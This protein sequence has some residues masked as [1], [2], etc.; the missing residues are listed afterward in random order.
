MEDFTCNV[1]IEMKRAICAETCRRF[2]SDDLNIKQQCIRGFE[3]YH[4]SGAI[5]GTASKFM[6]GKEKFANI[7]VTE[8][9][10][11][12]PVTVIPKEFHRRH[13][14]LLIYKRNIHEEMIRCTYISKPGYLSGRTIVNYGKALVKKA[15][16]ILSVV[17]DAIKAKILKR[18]DSELE[19]NSGKNRRISLTF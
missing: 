2:A 3:L 16:K 19:Y 11:F 4:G 6:E 5:V 13:K 10:E 9:T 17:K 18:V 14:K 7:W 12:G 15:Q 8:A 1:I